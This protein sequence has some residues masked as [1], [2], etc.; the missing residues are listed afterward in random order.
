MAGIL[1]GWER[2]SLNS[3]LGESDACPDCRPSL[4]SE[5]LPY[6]PDVVRRESSYLNLPGEWKLVLKVVF[7]CGTN[8]RFSV[9]RVCFPT[10]PKD[11]PEVF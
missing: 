8:G 5:I 7:V 9:G 10:F 1:Q 11:G 2:L 6:A 3:P 4:V